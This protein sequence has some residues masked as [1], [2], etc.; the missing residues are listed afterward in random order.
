[1]FLKNLY[2][3]YFG[4]TQTD[5]KKDKANKDKNKKDKTKKDKTKKSVDDIVVTIQKKTS[6][7]DNKNNELNN[8]TVEKKE[9]A[10]RPRNT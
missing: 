1:M 8:N 5:I 7:I 4:I 6:N 3:K 9:V 10:Q 2:E